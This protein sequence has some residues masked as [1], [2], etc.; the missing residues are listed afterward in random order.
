ML[1]ALWTIITLRFRNGELGGREGTKKVGSVHLFPLC[2]EEGEVVKASRVL[3][4][5]LLIFLLF[6][7]APRKHKK[8]T[9]NTPSLLDIPE[10]ELYYGFIVNSSSHFI[11]VLIWSVKEKR[12][13]YRNIVLPPPRSSL[14]KNIRGSEYWDKRKCR[15]RPPNV[16]SLWLKLGTYK[17][18]VSKRDDIIDEG[19]PGTG[20]TF[21]AVL[22]K[23]YVENSPGPFIFEI[24]DD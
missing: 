17:V 13:V 3:I 1:N 15:Y 10:K 2:L 21:T 5:I 20:K 22:D 7:C 16:F 11:E 18:S 19:P 9:I 23:E 8:R 4:F 6:N 14:Q 24:E 12:K